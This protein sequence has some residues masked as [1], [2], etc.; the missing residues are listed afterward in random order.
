MALLFLGKK[1]SLDLMT[2]KIEME[3]RNLFFSISFLY[4]IF[5]FS[6]RL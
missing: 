1:S 3:R 4:N 2:K 5:H 6:G